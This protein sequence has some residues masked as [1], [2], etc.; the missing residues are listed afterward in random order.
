LDC[1]YGVGGNSE[2]DAETRF[3]PASIAA[4]LG[5][6]NMEAAI[7][8]GGGV[9]IGGRSDAGLLACPASIAGIVG[10]GT[11]RCVGKVDGPFTEVGTNLANS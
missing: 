7:V 6:G 11:T 2:G 3:E 9:T 4:I 10:G 5:G 8:G 1:K